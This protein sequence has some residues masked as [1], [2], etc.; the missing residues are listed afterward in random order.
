VILK[1]REKKLVF[2]CS[3]NYSIKAD[4]VIS[5]IALN[6]PTKKISKPTIKPISHIYAMADPS[7]ATNPK[8]SIPLF[9][10]AANERIATSKGIKPRNKNRIE[11]FNDCNM[12]TKCKASGFYFGN[13]YL[14]NLL[15]VCL[16]PP[17][18]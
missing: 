3:L 8:L 14:R 15:N 13:L 16:L 6:K 5:P 2:V 4:S 1:G 17:A 18:N 10:I 9:N 7:I 12:L 11:T